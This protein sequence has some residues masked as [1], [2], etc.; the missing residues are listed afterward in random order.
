MF[1]PLL[2]CPSYAID[3][4][5][6]SAYPTDKH[7]SATPW[8]IMTTPPGRVIV[9]NLSLTNHSNTPL[10]LVIYPVDATVNGDGGFGMAPQQSHAKDAGSWIQLGNSTVHL[11]PQSTATVSASISAPKNA[12]VGPHYAG[13]VVQRS[14]GPSFDK[15]KNLY[16]VTRL[17][18]RVYATVPG[19]QHPRLNVESLSHMIDGESALLNAVL[20][21]TGN[22]ILTPT[23]TITTKDIYGHERQQQIN[24]GMSL[25][26]QDRQTVRLATY[27]ESRWIPNRHHSVVTVRYG[28]AEHP[29]R[30]VREE[31]YWTGH[32]LFWL[33]GLFTAFFA[34]VVFKNQKWCPR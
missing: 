3:S 31:Y 10:D 12:S 27:Q 20:K 23:G 1:L 26:P 11:D 4:N 16:V 14:G 22:T 9:D 28:N 33:A 7:D 24:I 30:I 34:I 8:F 18:V 32:P 29:K 17:G 15:Q 21:N 25:R 6:L 5:I 13:I 2:H 19:I